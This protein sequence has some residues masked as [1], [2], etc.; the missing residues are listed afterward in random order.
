MTQIYKDL[1]EKIE[2]NKETIQHWFEEKEK[3]LDL[4]LYTS[5][6]IRDAG[7]K[8]S[9]VDTNLFPAG[10]NNVCDLSLLEVEPDFLNEI[11][12]R[13]PDCKS[14]LILTEEHTRNTWYLENIY[15]ELM[16]IQ[17]ASIELGKVFQQ[18]NIF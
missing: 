4:P 14:I 15:N 17:P 7:F 5:V 18:S 2:K 6:D 16:T 3:P 1:K 10:F 9:V 11:K 8:L 13:V 12:K